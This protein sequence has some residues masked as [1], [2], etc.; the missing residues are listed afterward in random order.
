LSPRLD[1]PLALA[2]WLLGFRW[3]VHTGSFALL[4]ALA[5]AA[6]LRLAL[7]DPS[8]RGLLRWPGGRA[9]LLGAA[10]GLL[11]T[12]ATYLLYPP[13]ARALPGLAESTA[14][15]YRLL[16]AASFAPGL[17]PLL[18]LVVGASEEVVWRGRG[19]APASGPSLG[20]GDVERALGSAALYGLAHVASGSWLLPLLAFGCGA[21]WGLLRLATGSLWPPI[22]AHLVWSGTVLALFPLAG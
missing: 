17:L 1:L 15:L 12:A 19:L 22:L 16:G 2:A 20:Q 11:A 6:A 18:L 8:T 10:V 7:G 14:A 13:L 4:T 21:G 9:L 5:V 3:L